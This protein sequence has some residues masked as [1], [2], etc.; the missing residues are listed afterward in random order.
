MKKHFLGVLSLCFLF[1]QV[2]SQKE[3][4]TWY[5][6]L[7]GLGLK[8]SDCQPQVITDG[9]NSYAFEGPVTICDPLTGDLLFYTDGYKVFDK[10]HA[11]MPNGDPV[12]LASTMTQNLILKKP[13]PGTIY[14]LLSP[15][16]Q[17]GSSYYYQYPN[18]KGLIYAEIDL[19]LNQGAGAVVSKFNILVDSGTCEK[20]TATKHANGTDYWIAAHEY[21]TDTFLV[22]S[23]TAA[24]INPV[25]LKQAIGPQ[26]Y[27]FQGGVM[28][29]SKLDA[30]GEMKFSPDGNK[31]C[32][33]SYWNGYTVLLDF[34]KST[35]VFSNP[36]PLTIPN[37]GYGVAFSSDSKVLYISL[38]DTTTGKWHN[39]ENGSLIQFDISSNNQA[40]IQN[41]MQVLYQCSECAFGSLKLGP[42]RKIYATH[43]GT[44][45]NTSGDEYLGVINYP[46][47]AGTACDYVHQGLYLQGYRSG[48]GLN[49]LPDD[50]IFCVQENLAYAPHPGTGI[51]VTEHHANRQLEISNT[52]GDNVAI[53]VYDVMGRLEIRQTLYAQSARILDL[54]R[55]GY[56]FY[57]ILSG[58]GNVLRSGKI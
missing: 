3:D 27:T 25:P 9:A 33:T 54:P 28:G 47:L 7:N 8:F 45:P 18:A 21:G 34:D 24:G 10:N 46:E 5:F 32:M 55:H 22:Y 40:I 6:S 23:L 17:G 1:C 39:Q 26:V 31:L 2:F 19:S 51:K 35:G 42:D 56:Y 15:G 41:S 16:V 30:V 49:N 58:S 20:L 37:G 36:I 29:T 53:W 44:T 57:H 14:Y 52:T 48:W 50:T 43:Y 13:G 38:L 12:S 11:V 4:Y